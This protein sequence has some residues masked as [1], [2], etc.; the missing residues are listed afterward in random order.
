MLNPPLG[1]SCDRVVG[2]RTPT[3]TTW[4]RLPSA[5]DHAQAGVAEAHSVLAAV[6]QLTCLVAAS[7]ARRHLAAASTVMK[8]RAPTFISLGPLPLATRTW[9]KAWLMPPCTRQNSLML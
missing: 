9:K 1:L 6:L 7:C 4:S 5:V 2:L 3:R 8:V